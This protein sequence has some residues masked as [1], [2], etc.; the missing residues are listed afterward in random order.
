MWGTSYGWWDSGP[1]YYDSWY[2]SSWS[3]SRVYYG[4]WR[5]GWYGGAT[6][7][8][9]PWY[10][11]RSAYYYTEPVYVETPAIVE[12]A[13][14]TVV[15]QQPVVVPT[16][17]TVVQ[18]YPVV[19]DQPVQVTPAPVAQPVETAPQTEAAQMSEEIPCTCPC[20]CNGVRACICAYPCGSEYSFTDEV[21]DLR[22]SFQSYAE[23][24]DAERIWAS[25]E[26]QDRE[27]DEADVEPL[28]R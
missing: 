25:Y 23:T 18:T 1:V 7:V 28:L 14:T 3:C 10:A 21:M 15:I 26:G 16:A 22:Q 2:D 13:P 4:G 20:H 27:T 12:T 8:H 9:N 11:Y 24:L 6:Y 5:H 19:Q 17:P